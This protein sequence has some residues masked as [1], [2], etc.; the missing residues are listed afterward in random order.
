[1]D[2]DY[3]HRQSKRWSQCSP[4]SAFDLVNRYFRDINALEPTIPEVLIIPS[5]L[6]EE[7]VVVIKI[8]RLLPVR[9]FLMAQL[10]LLHVNR[11]FLLLG[12]LEH[13]DHVA[14]ENEAHPAVLD[15]LL[16]HQIFEVVLDHRIEEGE[17]GDFLLRILGASDY[18][19]ETGLDAL[20]LLLLHL[21]QFAL[22]EDFAELVV[23]AFLGLG[24]NLRVAGVL[25]VGEDG[26]RHG[27]A[28]V[29]HEQHD[30]RSYLRLDWING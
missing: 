3:S 19:S 6:L 13:V 26:L 15:G 23:E 30:R 2:R 8:R 24:D 29:D 17:L 5:S 1:M 10:T 16:L 22:V 21:V 9:P 7:A 25:D 20:K 12:A 4:S 14:E 18:V 28:V 11:H 27:A